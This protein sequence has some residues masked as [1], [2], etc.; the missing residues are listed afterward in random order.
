MAQH[1]AARLLL[2]LFEP[3]DLVCVVATDGKFGWDGEV[4]TAKEWADPSAIEFLT[5]DNN[6]G[7]SIYFCVNPLK[8]AEPR[9][10]GSSA[11]YADNVAVVKNIM[12]D[13]D[14]DAEKWYPLIQELT[15]PGYVQ[16]TSNG[17]LQKIWRIRNCD[18]KQFKKIT[19][20]FF[21]E[22]G[23]DAKCG[24]ICRLFRLPGFV[25]RKRS[26]AEN[27][28]T[29]TPQIWVNRVTTPEDFQ[30]LLDRFE[31]SRGMKA[32]AEGKNPGAPVDPTLLQLKK[33]AGVGPIES[34]IG[35]VT[36]GLNH[37][38]PFHD[39]GESTTHR[40][41]A[42]VM[43]ED[44]YVIY[45]CHHNGCDAK[46]DVLDFVAHHDGI[47]LGAAIRKVK[48][49]TYVS[50]AAA[51]VAAEQA[52]IADTPLL[53]IPPIDPAT[54]SD[55]PQ[56]PDD[57]IDGDLIGELTR[58]LV[59]GTFIPP[60][61]ARQNIKTALGHVLDGMVGFPGQP[62]LHMRRYNF[63]VGPPEC[64]KGESWNRTNM[65]EI[66]ALDGLLVFN[67]INRIDGTGFGSGQYMSKHLAK[68]PNTIV[69]FD[70]GRT[71]FEQAQTLGSTLESV[72][73]SL[74]E[75]N[76]VAQGSF[77]NGETKAD[78][79]HLSLSGGF[80]EDSF[81]MAFGG[82]G[83]RGSGFLSRCELAAGTRVHTNGKDWPLIDLSEVSRLVGELGRRIEALGPRVGGQDVYLPTE[84][85]EAKAA[86]EAFAK[87]LQEQSRDHVSRL[88]SH[89][90]RD[91]LLR[92]MFGP[93]SITADVIR[94]S[95][96][97]AQDQLKL[98]HRLWPDDKGGPVEIFE[99]RIVA[100]LAARGPL[101]DRALTQVC[102][103]TREGSGGREA[104]KRAIAALLYGSRE[105]QVV[106]HNRVKAPIY[107]LVT[108]SEE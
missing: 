55:L 80:T 90:K 103:V 7:K 42:F 34:R 76:S 52:K 83:S 100:A 91:I 25:N 98:R 5:A 65:R 33:D 54:I 20:A 70:E 40:S 81:L 29:V 43:A 64:G 104:F 72:F 30:P 105:I 28:P 58:V 4:R 93:G 106:A 9:P 14:V 61:F 59:D 89:F 92:A 99:R 36:L 84:T 31:A 74:F 41:F 15:P 35:Q 19:D 107:G 101:G 57:C 71:L 44:G 51:K 95:T 97:W 26:Y 85:P 13:V 22:L 17:K 86:R 79:V 2:T 48:S 56:H 39:P 47:D 16:E 87:W 96:L 21:G 46:G 66:G 24:D 62:R 78:N 53:V 18:E 94:R 88:L 37:Q 60:Q 75:G 11:R 73:L 68:N 12:L 63:L 108:D 1:D 10:G 82:R 67:N 102:H 6:A 27:P 69:Y 3:D 23:G 32:M 45:R 77:K 38:C 50:D 49:E 8:S